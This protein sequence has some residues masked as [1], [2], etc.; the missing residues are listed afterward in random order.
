MSTPC[1]FKV[2]KTNSPTRRLTFPSQ[3][4][5][6]D[7]LS[8]LYKLYSITPTVPLI[9]TY[10]DSEGDQIVAS[11]EEELKSLYEYCDASQ[12]YKITLEIAGDE[13]TSGTAFKSGDTASTIPESKGDREKNPSDGLATPPPSRSESY[14]I[15]STP[16]SPPSY[17][18]A[19]G[20]APL[21]GYG[22]PMSR[23]GPAPLVLVDSSSL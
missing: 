16:T 21:D 17:F 2:S 6:A 15:P 8:T 9:I 12:G 23:W 5:W 11:S 3:P 7:L 14:D 18:Q 13:T 10:Q 22:A 1:N 20:S 19:S 4:T